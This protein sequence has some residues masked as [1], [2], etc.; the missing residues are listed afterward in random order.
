MMIHSN[1]SDEVTCFRRALDLMTAIRSNRLPDGHVTIGNTEGV[2]C[3]DGSV[4]IY[5]PIDQSLLAEMEAERKKLLAE[6]RGNGH[7]I[8]A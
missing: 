8:H 2:S 3:R 6:Q 4:L 7:R 1:L 5:D